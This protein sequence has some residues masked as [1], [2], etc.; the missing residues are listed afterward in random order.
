MSDLCRIAG[1]ILH[2]ANLIVERHHGEDRLGPH[3]PGEGFRGLALA[4]H[5]L[6][7][8]TSGKIE[9]EY[10]RERPCQGSLFVGFE[11]VELL[12]LAIRE[13]RE[14]IRF[15]VANIIAVLISDGG[16]DRDQIGFEL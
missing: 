10:H 16:V 4:S 14:V 13:N 5:L 9:S 3:E 15:Q 2:D 7:L 11:E 8:N 12:R 1:E 6:G